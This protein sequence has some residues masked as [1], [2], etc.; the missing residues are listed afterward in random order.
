MTIIELNDILLA[1]KTRANGRYKLIMPDGLEII[2]AAINH[3][4]RTV[5]L[6]DSQLQPLTVKD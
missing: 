4:D 6:T 2:S 5:T 3:E 1:D